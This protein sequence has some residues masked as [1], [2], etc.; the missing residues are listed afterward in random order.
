M[1]QQLQYTEELKSMSKIQEA[2]KNKK[3]TIVDPNKYSAY[4]LLGVMNNKVY[5]IFLLILSKKY[6][7]IF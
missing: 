3:L 2:F 7:I 5:C 6:S 1:W 4:P